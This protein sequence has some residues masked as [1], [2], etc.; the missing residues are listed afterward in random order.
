MRERAEQVR[1]WRVHAAE[2]LQRRLRRDADAAAGRVANSG[3]VQ[4]EVPGTEFPPQC[5]DCLLDG[6]DADLHDG[7]IRIPL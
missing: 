7:S 2:V 4:L 1:G 6:A 5:S 3:R